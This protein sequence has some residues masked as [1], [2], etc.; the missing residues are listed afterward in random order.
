MYDDKGTKITDPE[1][2]EHEFVS[3][4]TKLIGTTAEEW[5]CLYTIVVKKG[6]CL[7]Y[8]QKVSL[9]HEVTEEEILVSLHDMP[10]EKSPGVDGYPMEFFTKQWFVVKSDVCKAIAEFFYTSKILKAFSCTTLTLVPKTEV[11]THVKDYR[12]IS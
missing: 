5:P 10:A 2:V 9:I 4:F 6:P 12:P 7:A 3:V 1:L 11:P 8:Q